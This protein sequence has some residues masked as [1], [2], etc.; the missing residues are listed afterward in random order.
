MKM[1]HIRGAVLSLVLFSLFTCPCTCQTALK[2]YVQ[3]DSDISVLNY[4]VLST[5]NE[6][7]HV[8]YKLNTTSLKWFDGI[9]KYNTCFVIFTL[10]FILNITNTHLTI[11][12]LFQVHQYGGMDWT[13]SFRMICVLISRFFS[14]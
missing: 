5:K 6:S 1:Y 12:T 13:F 8:L 7:T 2:A 10:F 4:T 3:D 14:S 11:K 9:Y